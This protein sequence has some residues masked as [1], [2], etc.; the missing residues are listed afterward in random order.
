MPA[1]DERHAPGPEEM[2]VLISAGAGEPD[3][4]V[5]LGRPS[6]GRV[7]VRE[8]STHNWSGAPD[9]RELPTEHAYAIFQRAAD[10]RRRISAA[11]PDIRAWLEGHPR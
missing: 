9:E 8:W 6:R 2:G 11:L 1:F 10:A 5:M 3:R 4:L 7:L